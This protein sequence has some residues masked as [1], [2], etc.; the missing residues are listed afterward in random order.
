MNEHPAWAAARVQAEGG[1]VEGSEGRAL[2]QH[3]KQMLDEVGGCAGFCAWLLLSALPLLL[4]G[5]WVRD[6]WLPWVQGSAAFPHPKP[7]PLQQLSTL[8]SA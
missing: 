4:H 3:L 2:R 1:S 7:G 8:T 5:V 6:G